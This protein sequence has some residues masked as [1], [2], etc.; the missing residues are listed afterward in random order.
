MALKL[1]AIYNVYDGIELLPYSIN[2]IKDF[3]DEIIIV[4]QNESNFGEKKDTLN[5]LAEVISRLG[6]LKKI[7]LKLYEPD[8]S[9]LGHMN[10]TNKRNIGIQQA[11]NKNCSHFLLMDCDEI[12][13]SFANALFQYLKSGKEGSACEIYT[14]FK[15][16]TLRLKS[17]DNYF[18]PFIHKLNP[19][20]ITGADKYPYY[21]DPTRRINCSDVA[22]INEP[23]HHF[24]WVRKDIEMKVRNSTAK[25]NILQSNLLNDYNKDIGAGYFLKDYNQELVE[26]ENTFYIKV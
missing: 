2:S 17:V 7:S 12:Y 5:E 3:V 13:F 14:Y 20:T 24:S 18:V 25:H 23:M 10:E 9:L 21:V 1:A 11:K 19:D 4:Y 16:P 6:V 22:L 26:V 8:P 15:K